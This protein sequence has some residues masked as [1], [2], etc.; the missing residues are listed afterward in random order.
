MD[1]RDNP[2]HIKSTLWT[3]F[4]H[5]LVVLWL[6]YLG[7]AIWQHALFSV[8]PPLYDPLSYMKKAKIFWQAVDQGDFVNP[9]NLEPSVRPLGTILMSYPFGFSADFHGFHFRSVF[10]PILC[11]IAAVYIVAGTTQGKEAN[12]WVAAIAFL[13]SSLPMFYHFENGPV[14]WG[15]V[16]NFQ[17]G[18]AALAAAAMVR[19]LMTKS[20]RWLFFGALLAAF[21]LL[22]KPSGLMV[23]ALVALTW[24]MVV[25]FE[26]LWSSKSQLH[27]HY[28]R[29]YVFKGCACITIVYFCFIIPCV[30]SNYLSI[31]NLF[32]AKQA[33]A[34][35]SEV[36]KIP[37]QQALMLFHQSSGEALV[38]WAIGVGVFFVYRLT[39]SDESRELQSVRVLGLIVGS[40]VIWIL[41]IWYWLVIQAGGSQI[42][43]F[44]P[45]MLMGAVYMV[46]AALSVLPYV[47]RLLR[48]IFFAICFFPALS[49]A[50]LL[51]AGDSPP[52][53][54]QKMAG[55]NVSV[56]SDQA[57]GMN[58]AYAFLDGLRKTNT[59]ARV[60]SFINGVN[61]QNFICFGA[62]EKI[63]RPEL[64]GFYTILPIDW[65]RG[66][67]VRIND[68]LESDY[69]LIE[70]F[71]NKDVN[72]IPANNKIESFQS[73][74]HVFESWLSTLNK[75]SG[76]E[77]AVDSREL[78]LLRV[79]DRTAF[80]RTIEQFVSAHSWRPEF[81]SANQSTW[82]SADT[83][84]AYAGD[85]VVEDIGFDGIYKLHALAINPI[86]NGIKIKAWWEELRH[87]EA[88]N[89]RY[90]YLHLVDASGKILHNQQIALF[91]YYPVDA[92]R[93]CR[94]GETTF[95]LELPDDKLASLAF[96][97]YQP[98]GGF[99]VADKG[100]TDYG[101]K[102]VLIPIPALTAAQYNAPAPVQR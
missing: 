63:V 50:G 51:A 53:T 43:Y 44:Y 64:A 95:Y 34:V 61:A 65:L 7:V 99:L 58:Q 26:K 8:Q 27:G 21:T 83:I 68:L 36:L 20:L 56:R 32:M 88:N 18:I 12:W 4:P 85:L 94:L 54:W 47:N 81:L 9:F 37:F 72:A 77:I 55:V 102:R 3:W 91:P 93:R 92:N 28:L 78:R 96:G 31:S 100:R 90:L 49:I 101:G 14:F 52:E 82:W 76:L 71:S 35:M 41:G 13:F 86:D 74:S 23:M 60:Y 62:Y 39:T 48:S 69:I 15:L 30:F 97:I 40:L 67:V 89:Q 84:S 73:E 11:I 87:E 80:G 10:L 33:L 22:V 98:S 46:P 75:Q 24:L 45:F 25:G 2:S 1:G 19:S 57:E 5:V 66:F 59:N 16:D 70:K 29:I 17:A 79:V 6:L 42:R 38:L